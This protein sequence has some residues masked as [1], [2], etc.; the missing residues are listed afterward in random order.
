MSLLELHEA[1][2]SMAFLEEFRRLHGLEGGAIALWQ[3]LTYG[4]VKGILPPPG[5]SIAGLDRT[6][7]SIA[8]NYAVRLYVDVKAWRP[9]GWN[10]PSNGRAYDL[11]GH[12]WYDEGRGCLSVKNHSNAKIYVRLVGATCFRAECPIC[13]QKWAS[14]GAGQIEE[15]FKRLSR[16]NAEAS[17]SGLGR[18]IHVVISVP[19]S[20]AH[21][22]HDDF[23]KLRSHMYAIAKRVGVKGGCA[24]FHPYANDKMHEETPEKI[25]IDK[26]TGKFDLE[27]LRNYY[28]KM[29][30]NINFWYVRPHFHLICYGWIDK[31]AVKEIHEETGYIV[32]N[33]GIRD[34]VRNTAH[35]QLSHCGVKKG[36]QTVTWFGALSNRNYHKLNPAPK[37]KPRR[38]RCPECEAELQPVLW[39][40]DLPLM[41]TR[42]SSTSPLEGYPE[43]GYFIDPGGWRYLRDGERIHSCLVKGDQDAGV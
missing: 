26:S 3:D 33:L 13:Y 34:S 41:L 10:L 12:I 39:A 17:V 40:P 18:P 31:E 22:M 4:F 8:P 9:F 11:C 21:L 25:L 5:Q 15:K 30:K 14:R 27:S 1:G 38:A 28:A 16:N 20:E 43:G 32:K 42:A 2:D 23:K 19:E 6:K 35:Y 36:V 24:I 7:R 37:F 29:G